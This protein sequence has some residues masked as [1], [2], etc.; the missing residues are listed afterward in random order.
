MVTAADIFGR[1]KALIGMVHVQAL[2]G[3][4]RHQ[5]SLNSIISQAVEEATTLAE[6]GFDSILIENMHD[7]PYLK[8]EVGPEIIA[9]MTA[10][11]QAVREATTIPLGVQVLAG[12]NMASLAVA[13]C[14]R[15]PV[16][17]C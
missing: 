9:S 11:G 1:E 4:P 17:P 13:H 10:V 8:R 14:R 2:P 7:V 15:R 12:A 16:H 5:H 6:L 3:T